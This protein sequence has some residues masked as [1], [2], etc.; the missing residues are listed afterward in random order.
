[1]TSN[2]RSFLKQAAAS[3][4][5]TAVVG[6]APDLGMPQ[7][8]RALDDKVLAALGDAILPDSL[9]ADARARA[10]AAFREWIGAYAP[11]SEEMHGYGSAEI[12]YT[13]P[14]PAPGWNAQLAALD[15]LAKKKHGAGF[16]SL[17]VAQRRALVQTALA[18][19]RGDRLPANPLTA[20]HVAVALLAHWASS[21]AASDLAW[22]ASI[23]R[24][25]CR[26]LAD[27]PRRP[28][29]VAGGGKS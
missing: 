10:T 14:D 16:A 21:S 9:G 6:C 7:A 20:P 11:V 17:T 18:R 26:T 12:T 2:R 28:L 22:G 13:P 5:A 23:G 1:M 25:N 15:L 27:A 24:G 4:A 29:P 8:G 19:V 3:V